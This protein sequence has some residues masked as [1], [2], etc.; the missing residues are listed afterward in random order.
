[1]KT[2]TIMK[3]GVLALI[4]LASG[5]TIA[6]SHAQGFQGGFNF[7]G[8]G[9]F[10][11]GF[12]GG[13]FNFGGGFQ[14]GFQQFGGG[15]GF[16]GGGSF[17]FG[18]Q[19]GFQGFQQFGGQSGFQG[20]FN[21]FG[22]GAA[23]PFSGTAN[24][25]FAAGSVGGQ[26]GF[27]IVTTG[28]ARVLAID[29]AAIASCVVSGLPVALSQ[30]ELLLHSVRAST[31]D[32]NGRLFRMRAGWDPGSEKMAVSQSPAPMSGKG[33]VV[34]QPQSM[35]M[36]SD[37]GAFT[38]FASGGFASADVD[39]RGLASG[40]EAESWSGTLGAERRLAEDLVLGLAGT[41]LQTDGDFDSRGAVDL[42]GFAISAYL[43]WTP[44]NFYVDTLYSFGSFEE[45]I[46]RR[47]GLGTTA[48]AEPD[49]EN[50]SVEFNAGYNFR[51][52]A[53]Q[54]G[55]FIGLDYRNGE[56]DGYAEQSAGRGSLAYED[57]K[58]DSLVTRV[59]WQA[60]YRIET[61]FG[62]ITPQIRAAWERENLNANEFVK[63][64]LT[65]SPYRWLSGG[66]ETPDY[67]VQARTA[68]PDEDYLNVGGGLLIEVGSN[69][70]IILDYEGH[71]LRG[72]EEEHFA[73]II[74]SLKF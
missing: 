30:R 46:H 56:L 20:G 21:Q 24:A 33:K 28:N 38:L 42:D 65:S 59:G 64:S 73:S 51:L 63:V 3:A 45:D 23:Q 49:S 60:S 36:S 41:Y 2:P 25:S 61:G 71:V 40:F 6:T 5:G 31:R 29:A 32:V 18:G 67:E 7:G 19:G 48:T 17:N 34:V 44:G 8:G 4:F 66:G 62:A 35:Q 52:G 26:P 43:S 55:P 10:Q 74:A 15:G 13:G 68:R 50:H 12:Q 58:Y 37:D 70:F 14:G 53:L 54:T 27:L 39:W 47:T 9:G 11:G 16:Q 57:Q 72:N 69:F 1:M 22:G